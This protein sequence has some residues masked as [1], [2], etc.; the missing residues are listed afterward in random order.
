MPEISVIVP[1]YKVEKYI[2]RC[3]DSILAQTFTDFELILVDDGS[4]DNCPAICDE[5]AEKDNRVHVIHQENSGLS[6]AR[7]T[8]IKW[9]QE[10]SNSEWISLVDSDDWIHASFLENL[11]SAVLWHKTKISCCDYQAIGDE[12]EVKVVDKCEAQLCGPEDI[13]CVK[14]N[15]G[16]NAYPW[17]YLYHKSL[18]NNVEYPCGKVFEDIFT[19]HKLIFKESVIA[20][21]NQPLYYYY[22]RNDSIVHSMWTQKR[23]D[24]LEG[25]EEAIRYFQNRGI[26]RPQLCTMRGYIC[27]IHSNY[28]QVIE[29]SLCGQVKKRVESKLR[30]KLRIALFQY[31]KDAGIHFKKE[32]YLYAIAYPKLITIYWHMRG[33]LGKFSRK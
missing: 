6:A 25:Y 14:S 21:M 9:A 15:N 4:P 23:L 1:V 30:K 13:Y 24:M 28:L 33:I 32:H 26:K 2:H 29:S 5:Y 11:L 19:T 22:Q 12:E 17:R 31:A 18:F 10:K 3:V 7:N 20:Y 8:G 27:A 16:I